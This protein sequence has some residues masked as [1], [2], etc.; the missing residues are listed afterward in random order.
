MALQVVAHA[1]QRFLNEYL[2]SSAE[3]PATRTPQTAPELPSVGRPPG[4]ERRKPFEHR[5]K[6]LEVVCSV[7]V[8]VVPLALADS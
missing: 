6:L 7:V 1:F 8:R 2:R 5:S 4:E 3:R